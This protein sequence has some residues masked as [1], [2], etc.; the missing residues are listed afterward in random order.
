MWWW[1]SNLCF[2][3]KYLWAWDLYIQIFPTLHFSVNAPTTTQYR[4]LGVPLHFSLSFTPHIESI[5]L[6]TS[7]AKHF[8]DPPSSLSLLLPSIIF[9]H[10]CMSFHASSHPSFIHFADWITFQGLESNQMLL[11]C[12]KPFRV[13]LSPA[14]PQDLTCIAHLL[15]LTDLCLTFF[16]KLFF[17][18]YLNSGKWNLKT[19]LRWWW[20][21]WQDPLSAQTTQT[22]WAKSPTHA[23]TDGPWS[24]P[25]NDLPLPF[26]HQY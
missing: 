3:P 26:H 23:C 22:F 9:T 16:L 18:A 12:L 8:P 5:H 10:N 24:D 13:F 6:F 11:L 7:P 20:L 1:L 17:P 19:P 14:G 2:C 4:N 25:W 15:V 21:P